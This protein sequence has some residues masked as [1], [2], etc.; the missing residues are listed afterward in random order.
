M[1]GHARIAASVPKQKSS[2][3]LRDNRD[4]DDDDIDDEMKS[5]G[6]VKEAWA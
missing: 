4:D 2:S 6:G 5:P 3:N 1:P